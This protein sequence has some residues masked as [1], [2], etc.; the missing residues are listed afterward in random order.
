MADTALRTATAGYLTR[1]LADVCQDLVVREADCG[2]KKGINIYREDGEEIGNDLAFR[3][4]GRTSLETIKTEDKDGKST[5]IV[6]AGGLINKKAALE[7]DAAGIK[8]IRVR[9]VISCQ[10]TK[11]ICQKCYGY[12][13]GRNE[14]INL[15]EAVGIVTAQAIGEPG[16][17][18]TLRTFHMGGVAGSGGQDITQGLPRVEEIFEARI[19]R[20]KAVISEINGRVKDII[21][22]GKYRIVQV[23]SV[24]DKSSKSKK[25]KAKNQV[26]EYSFPI[27]ERIWAEKGDL[28]GEGQQLCEGHIDLK[29]LYKIAGKE[30]V[31]RYVIKEVQQIYT[32]AGERIN[33]KHIEMI[34]RQ[35]FSRIKVTDKGDTRLLSG[36]IVEWSRYQ[37][38]NNKVLAKGGKP[39]SGQPLLM[40]ITKVSL[41]T[42]SFLSAASFQETARVLINASIQGKDDKLRG[43]KENVIIGKLIPAGTGYK[44]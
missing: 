4:F 10:S 41:S 28:I 5:I 43:L 30:A 19:P 27:G 38:A 35:M 33:D 22:R 40:G 9:S 7:I 12:D 14:L 17:Q 42:E 21:E 20:G 16:T 29:D 26:L 25:P 13:L 37:D 34:V 8:K 24:D 3:I 36:E 2:D 32:F 15:G 18:L 44:I 11:G 23:E 6:K 1:R 39:A 31:Q